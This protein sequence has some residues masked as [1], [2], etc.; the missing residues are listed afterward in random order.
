[1][2]ILRSDKNG[3]RTLTLNRPD[4]LNV[5]D[6]RIFI[7]LGNALDEAAADSS[8]CC[9]V[10]RGAGRSFCAGHDMTVFEQPDQDEHLNAAVVNKLAAMPMPT[11][12][13][14]HGHCYTGGLE[15]ALGC[16][17]LVGSENSKLAD[18]HAKFGLSPGWGLSA[19]LPRRIGYSR[20]LEMMTTCRIYSGTEAEKIGL[21]SYCWNDEGYWDKVQQFAEQICKNSPESVQRAKALLLAAEDIEAALDREWVGPQ[22]SADSEARVMAFLSK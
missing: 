15:L 20:A 18:T 5:L 10:L 21:L 14:I 2:E 13:A 6:T 3:V 4:R 9:L 7:E 22:R 11:I 17:I 19:R 1:M 8:V 12:A 16:D